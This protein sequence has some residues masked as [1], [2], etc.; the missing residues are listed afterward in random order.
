MGGTLMNLASPHRSA[1]QRW[2]RMP[3]KNRKRQ[4]P[5]A[6][7]IASPRT[8]FPAATLIACI[9]FTFLVCLPTSHA[10]TEKQADPYVR[11]IYSSYE[12]PSKFSPDVLG[13]Q[14]PSAFTPHLLA[15]IL[16]D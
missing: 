3:M 7:I 4:K 1:L 14:A 5:N 15:L 16:K 2:L 11:Q 8:V 13:K 12:H 6:N 9:T 10:Q